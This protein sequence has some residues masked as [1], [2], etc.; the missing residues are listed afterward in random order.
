MPTF[1]GFVEGDFSEWEDI[2]MKRILV[3]DD[4]PQIR[5]GLET[6]LGEAGFEVVVAA[7]GD[8]GFAAAS[9]SDFDLIIADVHMPRVGGLEM[10][11]LIR[12]ETPNVKTPAFILTTESLKKHSERFRTIGSA[13]WIVKPYDP[14]AL[15]LS[16][17]RV[18][19]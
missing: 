13:I 6:L 15:I 9:D 8:E 11:E 17:T 18:L 3:V 1:G 2:R 5:D 4:S 16:I 12:K 19:N 10:L 14:T 7:D